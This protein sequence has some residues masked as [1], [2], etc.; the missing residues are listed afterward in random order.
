M[1]Y[2]YIRYIETPYI[3]ALG[4]WV[5]ADMIFEANPTSRGGRGREGKIGVQGNAY[6]PP[7]N[8]IV[9]FIYVWR[10]EKGWYI[11]QMKKK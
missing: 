9:L 7:V 5:P 6:F 10:L 4:T 8:K 11:R 1:V 2:S 3:Y